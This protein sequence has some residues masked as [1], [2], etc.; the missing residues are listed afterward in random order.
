M[1]CYGYPIVM[2]C[3]HSQCY[4]LH[5]QVTQHGLLWLPKHWPVLVLQHILR[6]LLVYYNAYIDMSQLGY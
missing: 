3:F 1:V 6:F 5:C 4:V 2:L